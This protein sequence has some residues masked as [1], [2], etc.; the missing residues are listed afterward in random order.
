MSTREKIKT[1]ILQPSM[2]G[3]VWNSLRNKSASAWNSVK[4]TFNKCTK[5]LLEH[6]RSK[7]EA[8]ELIDLFKEKIKHL[9][10]KKNTFELKEGKSAL[11]QFATQ[12]GIE[13]KAGYTL[14]HFFEKLNHTS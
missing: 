5:W 1:P 11:K 8:D 3:K 13:G 2:F 6:I 7:Q 12:Y 10:I 9:D 4:N 14:N